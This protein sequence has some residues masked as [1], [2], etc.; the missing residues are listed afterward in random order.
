M[1]KYLEGSSHVVIRNNFPKY[2]PGGVR[3]ITKFL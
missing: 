3:E 2:L 1:G